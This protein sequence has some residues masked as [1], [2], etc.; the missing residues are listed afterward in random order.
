MIAGMALGAADT[1]LRLA[2]GWGCSRR[3]Y[4]EPILAIPVVRAL[5]LG[6]FLDI[7]I[8]EC[9]AMVTARAL[10][11]APRRTSLWAAATKYLVPNLCE[12]VARDASVVLSARSYLREGIASGVFQ[13]VARDVAITSIFEGTQLVQLSLIAAQL[14]QL[15]RARAPHAPVDVDRLCDLSSPAPAWDPPSTR[16]RIGD[17]GGDELV[18]RWFRRHERWPD[19]LEAGPALRSLRDQAT[20]LWTALA[21]GSGPPDLSLARRYC[22]LHAAACCLQVWRSNRERLSHEAAGGEWLALCLER[23]AGGDDDTP[24]PGSLTEPVTAWMLRQL[25]EGELFSIA[26][27]EL[28]R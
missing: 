28:A 26:P 6:S 5:L 7:L 8:G 3:L 14:G 25:H 16:L 10:T 15:V 18:E 12:R 17:P 19:D 13:K 20:A 1:A 24:A 23:L 11:L 21:D 22:V 4:G 2:L 9:V 27:F